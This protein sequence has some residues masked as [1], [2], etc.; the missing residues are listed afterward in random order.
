MEAGSFETIQRI[1]K[2]EKTM[3]RSHAENC[4]C[5]RNPQTFTASYFYPAPF[6]DEQDFGMKLHSQ[7][8]RGLFTGMELRKSGIG[9]W[10]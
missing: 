5:P 6:V 2:V 1:R 3:P 7:S 8:D 10:R 9:R 4:E